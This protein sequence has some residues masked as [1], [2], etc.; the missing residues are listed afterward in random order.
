MTRPSLALRGIRVLTLALNLPGPAAV[1]RL[2]SMGA[3]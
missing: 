3:R 1:K 2:R